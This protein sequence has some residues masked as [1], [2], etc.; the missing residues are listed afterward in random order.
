[1]LWEETEKWWQQDKKY[2]INEQKIETRTYTATILLKKN[3]LPTN[4]FASYGW[5]VYTPLVVIS[6]R[7][8]NRE[9]QAE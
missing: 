1:M 9:K 2:E 3:A 7:G 4:A 8:L 5:V 6:R